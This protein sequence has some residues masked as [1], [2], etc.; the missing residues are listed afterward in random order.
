MRIDLVDAPMSSP[1]CMSKEDIKKLGKL[2]FII[3]EYILIYGRVFEKHFLT[4]EVVSYTWVE[5]SLNNKLFEH[6]GRI[7][8]AY[9]D[10][11]MEYGKWVSQGRK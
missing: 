7:D 6:V 8:I 11:M 10:S 4:M 5:K 2:V 9:I 1:L 3:F